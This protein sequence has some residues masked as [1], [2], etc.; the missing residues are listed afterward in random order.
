MSSDKLSKVIKNSASVGIN[1]LMALVL[2]III[3]RLVLVHLGSEANGLLSSIRQILVYVSLLEAGVGMAAHQSLYG[4]VAR[5][6]K[7]GINAIF[8]ATNRYFKRTGTIYLAVVLV[9]SIVYP[10]TVVSEMS[11]EAIFLVVMFSGLPGVLNFYIH[12][13]YVILLT[14]EGKKYYLTNLST[15]VLLLTHLSKIVLLLYGF[16]VVMLQAVFFLFSLLQSLAIYVYM[17]RK[18][19]WLDKKAAPDTSALSQSRNVMMHQ[20]ATLIFNNTDII[21]LTY[22]SGLK[23]VSVYALYAM[24]FGSVFGILQHFYSVNF[25]LGQAFNTD[26]NHYVKLH[27]SYELYNMTLTFSLFCVAHLFVLPFV[28]LYTA[29]VH[30]APYVDAYLP[31]LFIATYL[32]SNGRSSSLQLISFAKH[33]KQTQ[34]RSLLESLINIIVS[35]LLVQRIGIYGVLIGTIA[36]LLYRTNDVIIYANKV[37]LNRSPWVTYRRWLINAAL[38]FATYVIFKWLLQFV[39]LDSYARIF[40]WAA[41]CAIIILPLFL[42]SLSLV[43]KDT[44]RFTRQIIKPRLQSFFRKFRRS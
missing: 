42:V 12:G 40:V 36:A 30:D 43:E 3:P 31:A 9:F 25:V 14:V 41:V 23:L 6:D 38:Y 15:L 11:R 2:G 26:M 8:A 21:I 18:Y 44:Y 33:F 13:K 34:W 35:L 20:I 10:F 27:D 29:G 17:K 4:P 16:D 37:L 5:D 32:L 19:P 39:V 28:T 7:P 1:Q 22:F 24:L